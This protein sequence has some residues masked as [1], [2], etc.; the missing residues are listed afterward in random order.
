MRL[1]PACP[2]TG[3]TGSLHQI[4]GTKTWFYCPICKKRYI[5]AVNVPGGY[6]EGHP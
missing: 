5:K 2:T 3:C 1:N 6:A 4:Y